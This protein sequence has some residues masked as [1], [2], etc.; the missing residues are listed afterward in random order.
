MSTELR[1]AQPYTG[2][3]ILLLWYSHDEGHHVILSPDQ[4][5]ALVCWEAVLGK[6]P[7]AEIK[8]YWEAIIVPPP[9]QAAAAYAKAA[10]ERDLESF[11]GWLRTIAENHYDA[12]KQVVA[13][14]EPCRHRNDD[15]QWRCKRCNGA[16]LRPNIDLVSLYER[17]YLRELYEKEHSGGKE[18]GYAIQSI[19]PVVPS[20][21]IFVATLEDGHHRAGVSFGSYESWLKYPLWSPTL[22]FFHGKAIEAP[23]EFQEA[24]RVRQEKM[25]ARMAAYE[26]ENQAERDTYNR[27]NAELARLV[28][29]PLSQEESR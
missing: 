14:F 12:T 24:S 17:P 2:K 11:T 20:S 9:V 8:E 3:S 21:K 6:N 1:I 25:T 29:G 18:R 5:G 13:G 16:L 10:Q 7:E 4:A 26:A 23:A 19:E 22:F 15:T 27:A 28:F